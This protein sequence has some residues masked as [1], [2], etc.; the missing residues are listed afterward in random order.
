[1]KAPR[2]SPQ[3]GFTLLEALI[4]MVIMSLGL[5]G[6]AGLQAMTLRDTQTA[7]YRSVATQQAYDM[8][9]RLRAN[10][11]GVTAG[12]YDSIAN[13]AG[14]DPSC[15]DN[16]SSPFCTAAQ[17]AATDRFQW[18]TTNA[19][20]LPNGNG[21]VARVVSTNAFDITV[22]WTERADGGNQTRTFVTRMWP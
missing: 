11:T 2:R 17:V 15:I 16:T 4:A 12:N 8:A 9:D 19:A 14:T 13:G 21:S 20:L 18:N 5:L 6:M 1:M 3:L 10:R 7:Y 22:S